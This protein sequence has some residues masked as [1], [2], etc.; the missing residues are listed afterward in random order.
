[1]SPIDVRDEGHL[2]WIGLNRPDK[3]NAIDRAHDRPS[4]WPRRSPGSH[5]AH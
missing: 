1:M 5:G 3:R 4:R 2:R